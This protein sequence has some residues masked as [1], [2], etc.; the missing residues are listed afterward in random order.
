M[1]RATTTAESSFN[2]KVVTLYR[3]HEQPKKL[4]SLGA[5]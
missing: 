2:T 1:T 3:P 5:L 4:G